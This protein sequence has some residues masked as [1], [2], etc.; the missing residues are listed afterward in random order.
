VRIS[1]FVIGTWIIRRI[2]ENMSGP[3]IEAA[4]GEDL[5]TYSR[6]FDLWERWEETIALAKIRPRQREMVRAFT[7]SDHRQCR[8][9]GGWKT[10]LLT[11]GSRIRQIRWR[12]GRWLRAVCYSWGRANGYGGL[13][14]TTRTFWEIQTC[15]PF[16]DADKSVRRTT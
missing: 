5:Q 2:L 12:F 6:R 11:K 8:L 9:T 7:L 15:C 16:P 10:Y 3:R 1:P 13:W 4:V 14:K